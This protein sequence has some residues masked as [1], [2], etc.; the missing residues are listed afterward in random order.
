MKAELKINDKKEVVVTTTT[1]FQKSVEPEVGFVYRRKS[2]RDFS[3]NFLIK[4]NESVTKETYTY[5]KILVYS[6]MTDKWED[7]GE[8]VGT[9]DLKN[10]YV[11]VLG[12]VSE[13]V[14]SSHRAL[15]G[16]LSVM[17]QLEEDDLPQEPGL[18]SR[19]VQS[20]ALVGVVDKLS[21]LKNR[22]EELTYMANCIIESQK[23]PPD[24][25]SD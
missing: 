11:R 24:A 3:Y 21:V 15:N 8:T 12:D 19:N 13:L 1:D 5:F 23:N 6:F 17:P 22:S 4:L 10:Y 14:E 20:E 18:V 7:Q 9:H 16:D 2:V 25:D